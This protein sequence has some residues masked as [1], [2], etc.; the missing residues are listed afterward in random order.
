MRRAPGVRALLRSAL[1]GVV[2]IV[3]GQPGAGH[4]P[5]LGKRWAAPSPYRTAHIQ[6]PLLG[7]RW[8]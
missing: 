8:C 3:A 2:L 6:A 4:A 5:D 1:L 7:K